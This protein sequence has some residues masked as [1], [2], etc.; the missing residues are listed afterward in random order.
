M[1]AITAKSIPAPVKKQTD[2]STAG[3]TCLGRAFASHE[4]DPRFRGPDYLADIFLPQRIKFIF[5]IPGVWDL[6]Y[7]WFMPKGIYEYVLARTRFMDEVF[8]NALDDG[9]AQIVV[10]GAG[11]DTRALRFQYQNKGTQIFELDQSGTQIPK[12]EI[13]QRKGVKLPGN[14]TFLPADFISQSLEDIFLSGGFQPGKK[15]LFLMEGVTMYLTAEA[16]DQTLQT[17]HKL[18]AEGSLVAF[19]YIYASVLR[20]EGRYYGERKIA[21]TVA[22]VGE[23]WTFGIEEGQIVPFLTSRGFAPVSVLLTADLE[24]LYLTA[25][26]GTLFGH[27]NG[28]HCLALAAVR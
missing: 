22:S 18:S 9:F 26:D 16:V 27:A 21:S 19:D 11:F 23:K 14:L 28:T 1:T 3:F 7:R 8:T 10:L 17:I 24:R 20:H 4:A 6:F 12:L 15:T 2:S 5:S 25:E 13:Y